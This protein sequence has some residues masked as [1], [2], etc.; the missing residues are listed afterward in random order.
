MVY[1][2]FIFAFGI[3]LRSPTSLF[4]A[5][6]YFTL[7]CAVSFRVLSAKPER[8]LRV[9][10]VFPC[11]GTTAFGQRAKAVVGLGP[12]ARC[13]AI[14]FRRFGGIGARSLFLAHSLHAQK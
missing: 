4:A 1:A 11:T 2:Y 14:F 9:R 13:N 8:T 7:V 5:Y 3:V 10:I 12:R 6:K